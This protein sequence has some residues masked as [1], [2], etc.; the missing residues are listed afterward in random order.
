VP[1]LRLLRVLTKGP[2]V[3][4]EGFGGLRQGRRRSGGSRP[5]RRE[6]DSHLVTASPAAPPFGRDPRT[7]AR[8]PARKPSSSEAELL[9]Y[10]AAR[11]QHVRGL[12][13]RR[14]CPAGRLV[15]PLLPSDGGVPGPRAGARRFAGERLNRFRRRGGSPGL[16]LLFSDLAPRDGFARIR[17]SRH[18]QRTGWSASPSHFHRAVRDGYLRIS[19]AGHR[20]D[21][22]F[23]PDRRRRAEKNKKRVFPKRLRR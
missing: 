4:F 12:I 2:F 10:E 9:L 14:S 7:R 15:R 16:T 8:S 17:G 21:R 6:G 22:F 1:L 3:T 5:P 11:A 23:F 13:F 20:P 18:G 19:R